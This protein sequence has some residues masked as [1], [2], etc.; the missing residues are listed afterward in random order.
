[1]TALDKNTAPTYQPGL[2]S[3]IIP[4]YR[5][6]PELRLAV[7]SALKQTY[8]NIEVIVVADG[9]DPEVRA[10]MADLDLRLRCIELTVNS[11]PAEARNAGVRASCGE[12]LTFLDDDDTMLP[13]KVEQQMLLADVAQPHI[14]VSCRT[15]YRHDGREDFWPERPIAPDED[16]AEYI[17]VRPSLLGR[18]G[19]LPIQSLLVH[20]KLLGQV[21]FTTHKDHEDWAWLLEAWHLAGARVKFLW[22]PLVVYNIVTESIS[23]SRRMNWRDSLAW[24]DQYRRWISRNALNSF[25]CTKVALKARRAG[26]WRGFREITG[27]VMRNRPRLLDLLFLTGMALL[28]APLLHAAWKR[29]LVSSEKNAGH[30]SRPSSQAEA[31]HATEVV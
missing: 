1:M 15:I 30:N 18:P 17:L 12:W 14:M 9:P 23:R 31:A 7:E 5:R 6:V 25:L 19:V 10:A 27:R 20:R 8:T 24:A 11:G 22:G 28:P 13:E 4:T 3:I 2:V 21:P 29:S 16:V 26:D